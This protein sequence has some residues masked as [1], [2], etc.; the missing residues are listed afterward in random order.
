M[1]DKQEQHYKKVWIE[2]EQDLPREED[3]YYVHEKHTPDFALNNYYFDQET[4]DEYHSWINNLDWY[5]QPFTPAS[6][7]VIEKQDEIITNLKEVGKY[8]FKCKGK[9]SK[10]DVLNMSELVAKGEQ[11]ESEL[12]EIKLNNYEKQNNK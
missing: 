9:A 10:E 12:A 7:K 11:L 6:E 3:D 5:L 4:E 1:K 2:S 8:Y